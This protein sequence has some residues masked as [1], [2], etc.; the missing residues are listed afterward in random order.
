MSSL[1]KTLD[2]KPQTQNPPDNEI[3][4]G[5]VSDLMSDVLANAK[6][7]FVWVTNQKHRNCV[8][9]ASLLGLAGI[10]MAGGVQPDGNAVEK[11]SEESVA[12]YTTDLPAYELIGRM[13]DAGIRS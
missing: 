9:I 10:I 7:G 1:A 5:Y 11:A 3:T 4:G 12:L 2:L 13:Y 8:A 6:A